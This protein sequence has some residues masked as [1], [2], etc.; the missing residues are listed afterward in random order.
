MREFHHEVFMNILTKQ[1]IIRDCY[2]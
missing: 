1:W 2:W